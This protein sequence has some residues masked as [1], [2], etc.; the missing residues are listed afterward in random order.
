MQVDGRHQG[1]GRPGSADAGSCMPPPHSDLQ[2]LARMFQHTQVQD[3]L[4]DLEPLSATPQCPS[5]RRAATI[6]QPIHDLSSVL[7]MAEKAL[8]GIPACKPFAH[9]H[10]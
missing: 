4:F 6:R 7:G 3:L 5:S 10:A 1:Q 2:C 9:W 8:N